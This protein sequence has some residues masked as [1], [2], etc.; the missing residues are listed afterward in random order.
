VDSLEGLGLVVQEPQVAVQVNQV[1][2]I[3]AL[4]VVAVATQ[5][6][7]AQEALV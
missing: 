7:A 4:V 5:L 2:Q 3:L 1:L 6:M